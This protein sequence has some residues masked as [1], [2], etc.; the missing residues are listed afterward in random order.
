MLSKAIAEAESFWGDA[1]SIFDLPR[2]FEQLKQHL[3]SGRS[4]IHC[5]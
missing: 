3:S 4:F 2:A 5:L 1:R